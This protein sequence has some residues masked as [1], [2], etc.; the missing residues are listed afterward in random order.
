MQIRSNASTG[1]EYVIMILDSSTIPNFLSFVDI[2]VYIHVN[3]YTDPIYI[4]L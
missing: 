3:T 4:S 2:L 1:I